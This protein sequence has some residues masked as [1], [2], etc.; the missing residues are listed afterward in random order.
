MDYAIINHIDLYF[1]SDSPF[2]KNL[3]KPAEIET[4]TKIY[5]RDVEIRLRN[6]IPWN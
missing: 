2:K 6:D 5:N 4:N 1:N 3:K